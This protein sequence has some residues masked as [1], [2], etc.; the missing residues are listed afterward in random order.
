[1]KYL[2]VAWLHKNVDY[3]IVLYSEVDD[4]HWE[5]RKAEVYADGRIGFAPPDDEALGTMLSVEPIPSIE[6]IRLDP[7]F[8][9][10]WISKEEFEAIW[11]RKVSPN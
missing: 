4:E 8:E 7:E 10:S 9:S 2:R 3:P 6:E 11:I 5:T 1:M